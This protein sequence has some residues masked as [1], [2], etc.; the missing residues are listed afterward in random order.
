[1][2]FNKISKTMAALMVGAL[3]VG[4]LAGCNRDGGAA[5]GSSADKGTVVLAVS[6]QTNPFFVQLVNGAKAEAKA[7]G[8][9]L[10]IQDAS[11]DA[12]TQANQISNAIS[13]GAKVVIVNPT[14]SDAVAPSV[15]ALNKAKIPVI[16]VDRSSSSGT[17]DSF[18]ASDNVAGGAQ[19]AKELATSMGEKGDVIQLQGTPGTSASRDRGKGFTQEIAKY[20]NIKV[21]AKQ[22]ANFDRSKALDVTTN[23]V[24]AHQGVTG[25]FAENDEMAL[26]A[27]SALGSKAGKSV[28]VIGFDGTADGLKAVAAGT[29]GASIAQ[30]P[31]LLGKTAVDQAADLLAGK[32]VPTTTPMKV[33]TVT[34][35]NVKDYQ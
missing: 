28:K 3:A 20:P 23:L 25:L 13:T 10:Q 27:I 18:I 22:T 12:A 34:K 5:S 15:K 2:Q 17:V 33:V 21:V 7:K 24:Q 26:G 4:G 6:T 9:T 35:S 30:Q 29:M 8:V 14:D 19:A 11:D 16:A 1:M 32:K 31:A